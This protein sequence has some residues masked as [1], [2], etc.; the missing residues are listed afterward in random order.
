[1]AATAP[2]EALAAAG[3][4]AARVTRR[5]VTATATAAGSEEADLDLGVYTQVGA[6]EEMA[7][8]PTAVRGAG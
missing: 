1:M 6:A 5:A 7:V 3:M 2:A 8:V 4:A